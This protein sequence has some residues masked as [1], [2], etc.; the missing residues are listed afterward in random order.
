MPII[1]KI[2]DS[3]VTSNYGNNNPESATA[4]VFEVPDYDMWIVTVFHEAYRHF[5][6]SDRLAENLT[7]VNERIDWA[8]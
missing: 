4:G 8:P 1:G 2:N 5:I 7:N 6:D 3:N